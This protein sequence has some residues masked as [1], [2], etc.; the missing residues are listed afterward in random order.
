MIKDKA[1]E[2]GRLVGQSEE[3][4]ALRRARQTVEETTDLRDKLDR[5]QRVAEGIERTSVQGEEPAE[6]D[7]QDYD[8]LLSEIQTD[9]RYQQ[10]VAAQTNFDKLMLKVHEHMAEGI[11]KGAESPIITLG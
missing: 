10:L 1:I 4:K 6:T 9:S 7:V 11:R 5:L 8:A 2:L 3:Y